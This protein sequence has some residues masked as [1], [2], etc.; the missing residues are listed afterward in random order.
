[1]TT[2]HAAWCSA[3]TGP[4]ADH[5]ICF[6]EDVR[7]PASLYP[8]VAMVPEGV[9]PDRFTL[10]VQQEPGEEAEVHLGRGDL[11]GYMMTADE[12]RQVAAALVKMADQLDRML[13]RIEGAL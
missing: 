5:D 6:S 11:A 3:P 10:Y 13:D 1:M 4:F 7:V 8:D 9:E 12:A 2:T